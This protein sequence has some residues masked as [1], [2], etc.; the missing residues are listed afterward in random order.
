MKTKTNVKAGYALN[1][2]ANTETV[3]FTFGSASVVW[4]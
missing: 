1:G 4:P 3:T 2:G